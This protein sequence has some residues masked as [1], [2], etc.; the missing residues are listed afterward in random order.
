MKSE[1]NPNPSPS[2]PRAGPYRR[3]TRCSLRAYRRVDQ[4][5]HGEYRQHGRDDGERAGRDIPA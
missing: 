3:T 2:S 5:P 4:A 1:R